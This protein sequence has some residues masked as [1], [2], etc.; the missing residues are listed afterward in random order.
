M[1]SLARRNQLLDIDGDIEDLASGGTLS[2]AMD[3]KPEGRVRVLAV[4]PNEE[5]RW[6]S[7]LLGV[8]GLFSV[9]HYFVLERVTKTSS[10]LRHGVLYSG[11]CALLGCGDAE[12]LRTRM[13]AFNE[14]LKDRAETGNL[15]NISSVKLPST[16][17]KLRKKSKK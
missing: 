12:G 2:I 16:V 1:R 9:E 8:P 14:A 17:S 15:G 3:A 10:R 11:L 4:K 7:A 6:R 13:V 5:F